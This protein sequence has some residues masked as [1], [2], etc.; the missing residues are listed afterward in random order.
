MQT[1]DVT[2]SA[3]LKTA[4]KMLWWLLGTMV[5]V[6]ITKWV[7]TQLSLSFFSPAISGLWD[8]ILS[9]GGWFS[10]SAPMPLWMLLAIT[11]YALLMTGAFLWAV[12]DANKQLDAADARLDAAHSRITELETPPSPTPPDPL[13]ES[14]LKVMLA[15][16][17]YVEAHQPCRV[18]DFPR[19]VGLSQLHAET[20]IDVLERRGLIQ[21]HYATSG[22]Y[23]ALTAEG[24][25]YLVNEDFSALSNA[26]GQ[27]R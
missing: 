11:V 18:K 21:T 15:I 24:R 25:E 3:R 13:N 16:S 20:A 17:T 27:K 26:N 23:I 19:G 4:K 22:K 2:Q 1:D 5:A 12:I 8:R 14:Q 9:V 10:Q 6:P 7:E